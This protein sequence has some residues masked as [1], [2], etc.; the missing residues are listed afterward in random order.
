MPP[1][2]EISMRKQAKISRLR[3][4]KKHASKAMSETQTPAIPIA[5][6]YCFKS[7]KLTIG[8]ITNT[9]IINPPKLPINPK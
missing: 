7:M 5:R 9:L 3:F 2:A 8:I 1:T 4:I 6:L